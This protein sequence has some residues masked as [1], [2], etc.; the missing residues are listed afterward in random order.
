MIKIEKKQKNKRGDNMSTIFM[1]NVPEML[2]RQIKAQAALEGKTIEDFILLVV[3]Q[4]LK[5]PDATINREI[6]F[7]K[8]KK[9]TK[10][11]NKKWRF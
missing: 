4:Y 1:R 10:R 9:G 6:S 3:A 11:V 8:S 2:H 5:I 7:L